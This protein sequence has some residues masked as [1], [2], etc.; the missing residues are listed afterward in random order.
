MTVA[1]IVVIVLVVVRGAG[2]DQ[3]LHMMSQMMTSSLMWCWNST[4]ITGNNTR[5]IHIDSLPLMEE[6]VAVVDATVVVV[7]IVAA[8]VVAATAVVGDMLAEVKE[9]AQPK[10][11]I[12]MSS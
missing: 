2:V 10:Q 12:I 4:N 8:V 7:I 6:V 3:M 9:G 11:D 5:S 1:C